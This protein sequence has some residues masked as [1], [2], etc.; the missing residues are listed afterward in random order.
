MLQKPYVIN[1]HNIN[2]QHRLISQKQFYS[3]TF[4]LFRTLKSFISNLMHF[5]FHTY[6]MQIG[7]PILLIYKIKS[8]KQLKRSQKRFMKKTL[9][10]EINR[11]TSPAIY[12]SYSQFSYSVDFLVPVL[13]Q[14]CATVKRGP[15]VSYSSSLAVL[16]PRMTFRK[17]NANSLRST[18]SIVVEFNIG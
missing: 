3:L 15:I 1:N 14:L 11:E 2:M 18:Y 7:T 17:T 4:L 10:I 13:S 5:C 8:L 12:P 9:N 16:P 6:C